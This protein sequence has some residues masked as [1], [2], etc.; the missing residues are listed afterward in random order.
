MFC[1]DSIVKRSEDRYKG[2]GVRI[3]CLA[4][5]QVDKKKGNRSMEGTG[6]TL[7]YYS[8]AFNQKV[9]ELTTAIAGLDSYRKELVNKLYY[10]KKA[11]IEA[12]DVHAEKY[13]TILGIDQDLKLLNRKLNG[14]QLRSRYEGAAPRSVKERVELITGALWSITA[15]P[16]KTFIKS[17]DATAEKFNELRN[18]IKVI[19]DNIKL[20]ENTL[21]KFEAPYTPSRLPDWK[22]D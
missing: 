8:T 7:Y 10:L 2:A 21:E 13:Q 22:K 3:Q 5:K 16:T 6:K 4:L 20:V 15:G 14:D 17:Y 12:S 19:D 18:S 11:V 9:A 1:Q